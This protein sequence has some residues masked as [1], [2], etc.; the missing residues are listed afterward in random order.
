MVTFCHPSTSRSPLRYFPEGGIQGGGRACPADF[1][2]SLSPL[3][4]V[5]RVGFWVW[6]S[7]ARGH[8]RAPLSRLE[9][10][11]TVQT[12]WLAL[13]AT[14]PARARVVL[15]RP[16]ASSSS[17]P[18]P[19]SLPSFSG[20]SPGLWDFWIR[21]WWRGSPPALPGLVPTRGGRGGWGRG[22]RR[23]LGGS[24]ARFSEGAVPSG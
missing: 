8:G 11:P 5:L 7:V 22:A 16:L 12:L 14:V 6:G 10:V 19:R 21:G 20:P 24:G 9:R 2:A 13:V 17:V 18:H 23:P 4:C 1:R 15:W 3:G